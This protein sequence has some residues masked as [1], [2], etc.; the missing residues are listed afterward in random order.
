MLLS[1]T[2]IINRSLVNPRDK[3]NYRVRV[4][5]FP[6]ALSQPYVECVYRRTQHHCAMKQNPVLYASRV[7]KSHRLLT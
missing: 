7:D 4:I 6:I 2:L 1:N 3:V 5:V